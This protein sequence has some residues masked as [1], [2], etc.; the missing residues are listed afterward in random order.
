MNFYEAE[1]DQ[2]ILAQGVSN[3]DE[4]RQARRIG[5]GV[6]LSRSKRDAVWPVFEE[7][8]TQLSSRKLKEVDDA[9]RDAVSLL[10]QDGLVS[11]YSAIVVDEAQD[12]GPQAIRL[13]RAMV[14]SGANDL[15]FVGDGHQRIYNRNK[16]ALSR[17]GIDIRGRSRKLYINYRTTDEIRKVALAYL[18]GC[19]IDDLDDGSDE[20]K[21]YKSLSRG[22]A[23]VTATFGNLEEASHCLIAWINDLSQGEERR[24]STCV[25]ASSKQLRDFAL[26]LVKQKGLNT[27]VVEANQS[28]EV[29]PDTIYFST[30]HRA[31]GL[32]F[33]QVI[34]LSRQELL[35]NDS[36]GGR[37]L[38]YV[39]LTRAR[40]ES[41]VLFI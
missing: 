19:E 33:D 11:E 30:M 31:K 3:Q 22:P 28:C 39:A 21:R 15:F 36:D 18:E 26:E 27:E 16:A 7:Y 20:S 23:P 6:I 41:R 25:I 24:W 40:R 8:R 29:I 32:E 12:L 5:R 37:K 9:Y 2:V 4:Y 10:S 34:V 14:A 1:L 38:L 13:L 35:K 17:C